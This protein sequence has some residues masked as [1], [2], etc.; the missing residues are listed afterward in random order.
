MKK[1]NN[2][3]IWMDHSA[4]NLIDINSKNECQSIVSNFNSETKEE[5][6]NTSESLMHNKRQQ[7]HEAYYKKIADEILKY[8]HVLLFGPTNAKVELHNYLKKD[9]HFKKIK[10]DIE[11]TDKMTDNKKNAFVKNHFEKI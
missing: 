1:N 4:A 9:L 6:L 11:P 5:A 10:I 8:N 3:G 2:L 7:M